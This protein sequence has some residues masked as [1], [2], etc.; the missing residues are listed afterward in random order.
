[1]DIHIDSGNLI[2]SPYGYKG[3]F[4]YGAEVAD[5]EKKDNLKTA[6]DNSLKTPESIISDIKDGIDKYFSLSHFHISNMSDYT[7]MKNTINDLVSVYG[8]SEIDA[9]S[10]VQSLTHGEKSLETE[11][12]EETE[13]MPVE[14]DQLTDEI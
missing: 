7:T 12:A 4:A 5:N 6:Q 1:M 3:D 2:L 13:E 11:E 14:V 10:I 9:A 8:V